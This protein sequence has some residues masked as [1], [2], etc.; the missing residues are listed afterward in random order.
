MGALS[1]EVSSD[2]RN[3]R[4]ALSSFGGLP[5]SL[6]HLA[7]VL[8]MA[9]TDSVAVAMAYG[10]LAKQH[11]EAKARARA[12]TT[13]GGGYFASFLAAENAAFRLQAA[14]ECAHRPHPVKNAQVINKNSTADAPA[15]PLAN[16]S[17]VSALNPRLPRRPGDARP[18]VGDRAI[19]LALRPEI[20]P[21]NGS[22]LR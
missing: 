6:A 17:V 19:A 10:R 1:V 2:G 22:L 15:Q 3:A 16:K 9:T 5:A 7:I 20:R 4:S 18:Y 13:L 12:E 8:I 21:K 11:L 14:T